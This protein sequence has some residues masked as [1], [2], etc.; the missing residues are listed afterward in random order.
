MFSNYS[1]INLLLFIYLSL[2]TNVCH[3]DVWQFNKDRTVTFHQQKDYLQR[4]ARLNNNPQPLHVLRKK[5][6]SIIVEETKKYSI[7]PLFVHA[8]IQ[9]ESGYQ[10]RVVS[11]KG[12]VGLMQLIPE[13]A[14]RFN[15]KDSSDPKENIRGGIEYLAYLFTLFDKHEYVLAAYNAGEHRVAPCIDGVLK[16]DCN[17]MQPKIPNFKETKNYV[18]KVLSVYQKLRNA[19]TKI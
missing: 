15:V 9:N 16:Q 8:L 7:D 18:R 11:H 12:A 17:R 14:L 2:L 5:Y 4:G 6:H 3:A 1:Q 19:K 13:T 10:P